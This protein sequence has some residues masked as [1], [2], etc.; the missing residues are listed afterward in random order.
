MLGR[1]NSYC[2]LDEGYYFLFYLLSIVV[3]VEACRLAEFGGTV[4]P[5]GV[6]LVNPQ[7]LLFNEA[8]SLAST[9]SPSTLAPFDCQPQT[10]THKFTSNKTLQNPRHTLLLL[11]T[12]QHYY[13]MAQRWG[14]VL[15]DDSDDEEVI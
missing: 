15:D 5:R 3:T 9:C 6:F 13:T 11:A 7:P 2:I 12:T 1:S 10:L 14:D 4:Q 8:K